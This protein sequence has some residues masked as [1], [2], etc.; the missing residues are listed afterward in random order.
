MYIETI[1]LLSP[2]KSNKDLATML[3]ENFDDVDKCSEKTVGRIR[4][5]LNFDY[6]AP[7][8]APFMKQESKDK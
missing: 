5:Q 3:V 7:L 8:F 6:K 4:K 1:T 2:R